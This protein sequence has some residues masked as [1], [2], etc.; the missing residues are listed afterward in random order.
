MRGCSQ[1]NGLWVMFLIGLGLLA[2]IWPAASAV[3][4]EDKPEDK[5]EAKTLPE[6][7]PY[8]ELIFRHAREKNLPSC[9]IRAIIKTESDFHPKAVSDKG[10]KGLMQ[11]MPGVCRRYGVRDPFNPEQNIRA[12]VAFFKD[13]LERF[14]NL[15]L[16]L[17]A[18]NAG[19]EAVERHK[20]VP[21]YEETKQY[22]IEVHK[23]YNLF[24]KKVDRHARDL[25]LIWPEDAKAHFPSQKREGRSDG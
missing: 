1:K 24:R 5:P 18:Y 4:A 2:A 15:A 10:A 13:M 25:P 7:C 23:N 14:R 22:I 12:G 11:L 3:R 16:A 17:A 6:K 20:G 8:D 19:P 9:L 21:P